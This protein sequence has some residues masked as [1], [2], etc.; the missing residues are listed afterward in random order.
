MLRRQSRLRQFRHRF[1][2]IL[3]D[4][5]RHA[6][7]LPLQLR[8]PFRVVV[9]DRALTISPALWVVVQRVLVLIPA[10]LIFADYRPGD[11]IVI[12]LQRRCS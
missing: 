1:F 11:I 6:S 7:T 2:G 5:D 12:G 9:S 10:F 8:G 4:Q 3:N